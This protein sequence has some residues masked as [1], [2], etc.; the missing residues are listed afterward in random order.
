MPYL[1]LHDCSSLRYRI[2]C[3]SASCCPVGSC[4]SQGSEWWKACS[5][6]VSQLA[7]FAWSLRFHSFDLQ[8]NSALFLF[9]PPPPFFFVK[10]WP[11]ANSKKVIIYSI[12]F[13]CFGPFLTSHYRGELLRN[14]HGFQDWG[15]DQVHLGPQHWFLCCCPGLRRH[16]QWVAAWY[17][18]TPDMI[19]HRLNDMIHHRLNGVDKWELL[20]VVHRNPAVVSIY[21]CCCGG[22]DDDDEEGK[23]SDGEDV[24]R[25]CNYEFS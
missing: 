22:D 7:G 5:R 4:R 15:R 23:K 9:V 13:Y 25:E 3:H 14:P 6:G 20:H 16:P 24:S 19:H 21:L 12:L 17:L 18:T 2:F 11:N 10:F 1:L 8:T